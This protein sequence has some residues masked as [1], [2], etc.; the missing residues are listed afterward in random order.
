MSWRR[1]I[2][3]AVF[4]LL[5]SGC[6][7]LIGNTGPVDEK[8]SS[9]SVIDLSK[10]GGGW[11][12]ANG[13]EPKLPSTAIPDRAYRSKSSASVIAINSECRPAVRSSATYG[14]GE[15]RSL[16]QTLYLGATKVTDWNERMTEIDGVPALHTLFKGRISNEVV[17]MSSFV[18]GVRGC[19]YYLI[20]VSRPD[21]FSVDE[22]TFR[23]FVSSFQLKGRSVD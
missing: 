14:E 2:P 9:Y 5:A 3:P 10:P 13:R 12:R 7:T 11:E 18:L 23:R 16:T 4:A 17:K 15:L 8:S 22:P 20:F 6:G 19:V 1:I 21:V